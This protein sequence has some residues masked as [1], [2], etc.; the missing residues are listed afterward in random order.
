MTNEQLKQEAIKKAKIIG[1]YKITSPTSRVYIGKS[2]NVY[3][4]F[5]RYKR[6]DC[7][8]QRKLYRSFIKHGVNN[9]TFE[10]IEECKREELIQKE[11]HWQYYY[12]VLEN[13]LNC[14]LSSTDT[15]KGEVSIQTRLLLSEKMKGKLIGVS[16]SIESR[17]KQSA[18]MRGRVLSQETKDKMS[19][20]RIGKN[21][22]LESK[23]KMS[24]VKKGS[25]LSLEARQAQSIR[26]KGK[27][28][29]YFKKKV[30]LNDCEVFESIQEASIIKNI[31]RNS[32]SRNLTG[33]SKQTRI[34]T[35][36][37]LN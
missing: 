4:R 26:Q 24:K 2:V 3:T 12:N 32:I 17:E 9:H 36:K 21:H 25:K 19:H 11:R 18:S 14:L 31:P 1:I 37:Y 30:I 13:G 27:T 16:R 28:I 8:T 20:T 33:L 7:I 34:G 10:I 29:E 23:M 22:S 5:S 35:W 6:L 15:I